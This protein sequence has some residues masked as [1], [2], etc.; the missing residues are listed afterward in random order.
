MSARAL[1]IGAS[2]GFG[3][4]NRGWHCFVR[5]CIVLAPDRFVPDM[6]SISV[7]ASNSGSYDRFAPDMNAIAVGASNSGKF[8][9]L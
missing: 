5:R 4:V 3:A 9:E 6:K 8:R 2:I 1:V 7:S